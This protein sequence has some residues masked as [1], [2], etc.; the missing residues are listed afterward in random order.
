MIARTEKTSTKGWQIAG[1]EKLVKL[2][3]Q[4]SF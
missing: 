3:V 2:S 1:R 4:K